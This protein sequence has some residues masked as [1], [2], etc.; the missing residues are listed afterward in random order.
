MGPA[1]F[2]A[3]CRVALVAGLLVA[4]SQTVEPFVIVT[5]DF[6]RIIALTSCRGHRARDLMIV[7]RTAK[8]KLA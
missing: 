3:P 8:M 6:G 4:I 2:A 5:R 7:R 1:E